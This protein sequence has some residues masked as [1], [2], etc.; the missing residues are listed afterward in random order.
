MTSPSTPNPSLLLPIPNEDACSSYFAELVGELPLG[1]STFGLVLTTAL[2]LKENSGKIPNKDPREP[3]E[4]TLFDQPHFQS[5]AMPVFGRHD[6]GVISSTKIDVTLAGTVSSFY[7]RCE[8]FLMRAAASV[9]AKERGIGIDDLNDRADLVNQ[10]SSGNFAKA[11]EQLDDPLVK[12]HCQNVISLIPEIIERWVSERT[13]LGKDATGVGCYC[14]NDIW[15]EPIRALT[16][17]RLTFWTRAVKFVISEKELLDIEP[18]ILA[19]CQRLEKEQGLV[20]GPMTEGDIGL[21]TECNKIK[22]DEEY[23]KHIIKRSV[24]FRTKEGNMVAWA[25]THGDFSIAALHVLPE[26]RKTGLGKLIL[27]SIA[28]MHTRLARDVLAASGSLENI[29]AANSELYAHADCVDDNLP[30]MAFMERCG[31]H[32]VGNYLWFEISVNYKAE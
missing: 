19:E 32:R 5:K 3:D 15:L 31:W 18:E 9:A 16:N 11:L 27:N 13:R 1:L 22:Y 6:N 4:E 21:M 23:C 10:A 8:H 24:C 14:I 25:G 7:A 26:Y 30:T 28:L 12:G 20:L 29:P 17:N 2:D